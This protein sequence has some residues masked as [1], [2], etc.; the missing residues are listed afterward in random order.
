MEPNLVEVLSN[1]INIFKLNFAKFYDAAK[2]IEINQT[3]AIRAIESNLADV[4]SRYL[5]IIGQSQV[6]VNL[7]QNIITNFNL[8]CNNKLNENKQQ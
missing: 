8:N 4:D 5:M 1:S 6:S 2:N 7:L 3:K